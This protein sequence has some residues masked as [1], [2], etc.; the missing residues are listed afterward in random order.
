MNI[1]FTGTQRGMTSEQAA[2]F[3]RLLAEYATPEIHHPEEIRFNHGNC[4]GADEQAA[5]I[6]GNMG[7]WLVAYP[8]DNPSKQ[9]T[10]T[11]HHEYAPEN[12][13]KRNLQII[14]DSDVIFACPG[15]PNEVL[16]S[17][18][19][20]TVRHARKAGK[21][22]IVIMPGGMYTAPSEWRH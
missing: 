19:W 21:M 4:I 8:G 10:I 3:S 1:G 17:G 20:M 22:L 11:S 2:V 5:M 9:S 6:A 18:T 16:R 15:E 7:M 12:N 13:L 14:E